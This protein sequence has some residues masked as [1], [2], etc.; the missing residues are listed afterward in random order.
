MAGSEFLD[1]LRHEVVGLADR[2]L[3][4]VD[5][6]ELHGLPLVFERAGR[7]LPRIVL[8]AAPLSCGGT[9]CRWVM[10]SRCC[11]FSCCGT[12]SR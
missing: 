9:F 11:G 7:L 4:V 2:G 5:E 1:R 8:A 10:G 3:G 12:F 6:L